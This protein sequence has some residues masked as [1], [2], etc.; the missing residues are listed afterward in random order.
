MQGILLILY[1]LVVS[2]LIAVVGD[3][4]GY[5]IGKKRLSWFNMRPRHTAI[6]VA[7][8]TGMTISGLTLSTLLL[9]NRNLAEAI[10]NYR[11]TVNTYQFYLDVLNQQVER[12]QS[13]LQALSSN[14]DE[15]TTQRGD[16]QERL[17]D[18]LQQRDEAAAKL[19]QATDELQVARENLEDAQAKLDVLEADAGS[20]QQTVLTL[21]EQI[22]ELDAT[23]QT[24]ALDHDQLER[25]LGASQAALTTL[26]NQKATLEGE[27]ETLNELAQQFRRGD[28]RI[29][30]GEV[31]ATGIIT[32]PALE[33][34]TSNS[35]NPDPATSAWEQ[36]EQLQQQ[37]DHLLGQAEQ[38]A[39]ILGARPRPPLVNAIQIRRD[40]IEELLDKL[41]EPG[42]WAIRVFS[43]S[44]RLQGEPVPIAIKVNPNQLIFSEGDVLA[45]TT[46]APF[47]SD[48]AIQQELITLLSLTNI[49]AQE[50]GLLAN[51]LT[52]S[53]GELSQVELLDTV[54]QLTQVSAPATVEVIANRDIF[55]A[56]RLDISFTIQTQDPQN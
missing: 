56:N 45:S 34:S 39:L 1:I 14:L 25:S 11:N 50:A 31:L 49:R 6:L 36:R 13:Q 4:V 46:V 53:V 9:L 40:D 27:I 2:G 32:S 47:Q 44:N 41:S 8:L 3:R 28:I 16:A 42:E 22:K 24:L 23:K 12:Q 17:A 35:A 20:V 19:Q 33:A 21:Q 10:F 26:E 51:P 30:S 52:G 18:L 37:L 7:V 38:Q 29:L 43:T 48:E 54:N 55:A 5:R 15:V